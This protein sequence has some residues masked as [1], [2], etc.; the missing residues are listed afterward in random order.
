MENIKTYQDEYENLD[1]LGEGAFAAVYKVRHKTLGYIRTVRRL[2]N[3]ITD[4]NDKKYKDFIEECRLLL[5]LGNGGHPNILKINQP[6]LLYHREE[7]EKQACVEMEYIKGLDIAKYLKA[8]NNFIETEEVVNFV[9]NI[10]SALA[11]CHYD[12]YE[13]LVDRDVEYEY[14]L[15]SNLKGQKFRVQND[16]R[17][18]SKLSITPEQERELVNHFKVLHNDIHA[19][20]IIRKYNGDY[21]LLDFGLAINGDEVVRSSKKEA[22]VWEY[23]SPERFDKIISEQSDIYAFGC[24]AYQMLAGRLPFVYSEKDKRSSFEPEEVQLQRKHSDPNNFPP[25]IEPLRRAAFE[26]A[27]TGITYTK[28]YPEWLEEVIMKC[29]EKKSKNRY[30]NGKELYEA[31]MSVEKDNYH[32]STNGVQINNLITQNR[33]LT[34]KLDKLANENRQ[35]ENQ[36]AIVKEKI[37]EIPKEV[38]VKEEVI[39]TKPV[40][41]PFWVVV[42]VLLFVVCGVL[43]F[44]FLNQ[45]A[46]SATDTEQIT[47]MQHQ[48]DDK[49]TVINQLDSENNSLKQQIKEKDKTISDRNAQINS[50]IENM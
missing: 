48:L 12:I 34:D 5:L 2:K 43:A 8:N 18:G 44:N 14:K 33:I 15:S 1:K 23:W 49:Q 16:S 46:V 45:S 13:F 11:Y 25:A 21:I 17:D 26:A 29:L 27:N 30:A 39:V 47:E 31:I 40:K 35:L 6:R 37:V 20:N 41:R 19:G 32:S 28:D 50:L 3:N 38:I 4:E 36:K 7:K 22:G 24:L 42:S 10:S 9:K